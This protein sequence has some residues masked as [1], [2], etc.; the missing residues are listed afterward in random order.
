MV[1]ALLLLLSNKD[2]DFLK[3]FIKRFALGPYIVF[4]DSD[5]AYDNFSII[6][7]DGDCICG[8]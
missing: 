3:R 1:A 7:N 5:C 8:Y 4:Y 6:H 2:L